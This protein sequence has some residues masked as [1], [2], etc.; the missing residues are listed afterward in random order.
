[1]SNIIRP[2][3]KFVGLHAHSGFSNSDGLGY[4]AQHIDFVIKNG[5]DAWTLTDHGNGSGLAHAHS[6]AKKMQK[7][8]INY[9]QLNGVEFYFVPSLKE[10]RVQYEQ[11]REEVAIAKSEKKA[12]EAT[13]IDADTDA[14]S[15]GHVVENEEETKSMS[16]ISINDEWKRRYHLVVIAKNAVGLANLFTLVKRSFTDGYYKFP[17]ID[18]DLLKEY[19]EGLIVSSACL[20]GDSM[21][22]TDVGNESL[23]NLVERY[24]NGERTQVL[25]FNE[26]TKAKE[27]KNV[28][29]GD[30]TRKNA[31][32]MK[33]TTSDNRV[34]KL[35]HDHKVLTDK[36]WLRAD[37]L[38]KNMPLK[39]M[40]LLE[41]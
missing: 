29:W 9:R 17:R 34:L 2:P 18:F 13:D 20:S 33:I 12:K 30:V 32:L 31:K 23:R 40:S 14:E 36:G 10:W 6:A 8:G 3:K 28:M 16:P 11:H 5:M 39:I 25:S 22:I 41:K 37:E 38:S 24:K 35:T 27:M 19:G 7:Q 15:A 21:L 4:P 1:M 26:N